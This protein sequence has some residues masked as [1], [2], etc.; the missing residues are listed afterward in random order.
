M[1]QFLPRA[2]GKI[3]APNIHAGKHHSV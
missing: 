2:M 1:E 3:Q